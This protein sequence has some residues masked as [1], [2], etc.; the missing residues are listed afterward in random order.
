MAALRA[1]CFVLLATTFAHATRH[2]RRN[3][4]LL[5][6][7]PPGVLSPGAA[8]TGVRSG[9]LPPVRGAT[10]V[11]RSSNVCNIS[12]LLLERSK[13]GEELEPLGRGSYGKVSRVVETPSYPA[14]G[15]SNPRHDE[16]L[17]RRGRRVAVTWANLKSALRAPVQWN[18]TAGDRLPCHRIVCAARL[19]SK[20]SSRSRKLPSARS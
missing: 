7:D 5:P 13:L 12:I 17:R 11:A 3:V 10:P 9:V 6:E 1:W 20:R 4:H 8:P 19:S 18:A 2:N 15:V 14:L 16:F